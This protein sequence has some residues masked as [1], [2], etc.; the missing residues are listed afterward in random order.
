MFLVEK[1]IDV[2]YVQVNVNKIEKGLPKYKSQKWSACT[3]AR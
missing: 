3:S 2:E 1:N